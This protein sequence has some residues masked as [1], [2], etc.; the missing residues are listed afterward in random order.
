MGGRGDA[1]VAKDPLRAVLIDLDG[2]IR[3]WDGG[4]D[5]RAERECGLADGAIR[6]A[7]FAPELVTPAISGSLADERWRQLV[8]GRLAGE[9]PGGDAARAVAMWSSSV[10]R[11]NPEVMG[12]VRACRAA[13]KV[14]L[15]VTNATSRLPSDLEALGIGDEFDAVVKS[16]AI[17]AMKPDP[18]IYMRARA[19]AGVAP[20]EAV[21][22]D[23]VAG[24]GEA[25]VVLGMA[26]HVYQGADGL[27]MCLR[28]HGLVGGRPGAG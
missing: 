8:V 3:L 10:G 22:V 21:M 26:G 6:R 24:N 14:V 16:S 9:F 4:Q 27:E 19:A 2:V 25:A 7:A 12:L 13:T 23:D 15:L 18:E 5:R 20:A 11:V 17:G 1:G 28:G